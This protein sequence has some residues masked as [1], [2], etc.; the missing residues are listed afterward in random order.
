[1]LIVMIPLVIIL[2]IFMFGI[3]G[4]FC[5]VKTETG[6][7][8][9]TKMERFGYWSVSIIKNS[10]SLTVVFWINVF[11]LAIALFAL[12]ITHL[13]EASFP[14]RCDAIRTTLSM[15]RNDSNR[16]LERIAII[17]EVIDVNKKIASLKY[18]N[19]S[20]WIEWFIPDKAANIEFIK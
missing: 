19:N 14:E 17:R 2:L 18:W 5:R 11:V 20:I 15:C 7:K 10:T 12:S 6:Y 1:M 8:A 3:I 13:D 16:D 4:N 9:E